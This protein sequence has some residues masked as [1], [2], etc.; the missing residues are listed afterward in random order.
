MI[1]W[2]QRALRAEAA[3]EEALAERTRLWQELHERAASERELEYYRSLAT[4]MQ[5][6]L[7]WRLT[8]PLRAVKRIML[9]PGTRL[10]RI[11]HDLRERNPRGS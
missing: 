7:S 3:L 6:S 11:G 1:D 10:E 8:A 9:D 4:K 5:G 2:E